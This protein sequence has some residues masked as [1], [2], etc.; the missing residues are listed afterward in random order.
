[1]REGGEAAKEREGREASFEQIR[2]NA[3]RARTTC[4]SLHALQQ[5]QASQHMHTLFLPAWQQAPLPLQIRTCTR[6]SHPQALFMNASFIPAPHAQAFL[7]S[8][9]RAVVFPWFAPFARLFPLPPHLNRSIFQVAQTL[10]S[11]HSPKKEHKIL[12]PPFPPLTVP[13]SLPRP[14]RRTARPQSE[15][16]NPPIS[17]SGAFILRASLV[18]CPRLLPFYY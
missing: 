3:D 17:G 18:G 12:A 6:L 7:S 8:G 16:R 13:P 5:E 4:P 10:G 11:M 15:A 1:M 2:R 14:R 9:I